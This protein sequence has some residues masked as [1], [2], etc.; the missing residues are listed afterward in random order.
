MKSNLSLLEL[1]RISLVEF[2][3]ARKESVASALKMRLIQA[4]NSRQITSLRDLKVHVCD[5]EVTVTGEVDSYYH[6]QVAVNAC[7]NTW[8]MLKLID[9]IGVRSSGD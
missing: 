7:L 5:G 9:K 1:P 4:L 3:I 2:A 6:R 8:G